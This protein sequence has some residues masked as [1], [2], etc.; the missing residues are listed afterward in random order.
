MKKILLLL[1]CVY[2]SISIAQTQG[3]CIHTISLLDNKLRPLT[4]TPVTLIET[5]SKDRVAKYT[6]SQGK[7]TFELKEHNTSVT[8]APPTFNT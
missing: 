1:F 2:S 6:D 4:N 3:E 8:N 7:V 5:T